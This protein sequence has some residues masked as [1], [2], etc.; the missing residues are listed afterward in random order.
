MAVA[1]EDDGDGRAAA[2]A[3]GGEE[4]GEDGGGHGGEVVLDVDDEEGAGFRVGAPLPDV[5]LLVGR[6]GDGHR[7][8]GHGNLTRWN[9]KQKSDPT[10]QKLLED[11]D[12]T[13]SFEHVRLEGGGPKDDWAQK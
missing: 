13:W 11:D 6:G 5:V 9:W 4:V 3:D 7:N 2:E 1:G 10:V 8:S 12:S